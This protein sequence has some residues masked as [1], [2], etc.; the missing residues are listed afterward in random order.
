MTEPVISARSVGKSYKMYRKPSDRLWQG[1][2]RRQ[3]AEN[4]F[5]ALRDVSFQVMRGETVGIVG[6]NGSGKSTLL[7]MIAGTVQPSEGDVAVKG[8]VAA[9]LELGSGFNPEFTG[10][11]NVYLNATILGLTRAQV[12]ERFNSIAEFADIGEFID[13]PVRSYSSGM[14]VRLAF[15]VIVHVDAD[16]LIVDEALSVGDAF[17]SQKCMRFLREFQKRGTLLFVSHDAGAVTNL[18]ARAIW[19]EEGRVR[20][21]GSA[22]DVVEH[23]MAQQHAASR[24]KLAGDR[25]EVASRPRMTRLEQSDVTA[26][27]FRKAAMDE[28][29]LR[30]RIHTFEFDVEQSGVQFGAGNATITSVD[31]LDEAGSKKPLCGAELVTLQI[32]VQLK[33]QLDNLIVGFYVKDRLGQRLFGDNTYFPYMHSPISGEVGEIIVVDFR[34]R[35]PLLPAGSYMIDAAVASGTQE[36]HTQ[37]HWIHDALEF[38]ALDDS[39]AHGLV[40]IPML[41]IDVSRGRAE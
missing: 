14:S 18:C 37:Q 23:Y 5:W 34:F 9:L 10:R 25:V 27:D 11:E 29:G 32:T 1:I 41:S 30:N 3:M 39:M 26:P 35:M 15:A 24:G 31:L 6:K 17:F 7:Q 40:G 16:V 12:D 38:R 36:D 19:L 4:D 28:L 21:Q 33:D 22:Q 2:F 13:Q 20:M 8:R